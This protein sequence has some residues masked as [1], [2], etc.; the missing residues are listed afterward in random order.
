[1]IR[2]FCDMLGQHDARLLVIAALLCTFAMSTSTTL[3]TRAEAAS[4][5]VRLRWRIASAVAFGSGVWAT[6]FIAMLAYST[7]LPIGYDVGW[8]LA[9]IVAAIGIAFPA[10]AFLLRDKTEILGG[11][12]LGLAIAA[13]HYLGMMAVDGPV[14]LEWNWAGVALSIAVGAGFSV[15]AILA[16]MRMR[17]VVGSASIVALLLAAVLET[18]LIGMYA[19]SFVYDPL[20]PAGPETVAPFWLACAVAGVCFVI[21]ALGL[22]GAM[23]DRHL[24][25]LRSAEATRLHD[26]IAELER[27]RVDLE[28][29]SDGLAYALRTASAASAAKSA[30][31]A[32]MSHELRTPLNAVIGFSELML[33]EAL[34]P[35]GQPRYKEYISDIHNSGAHLL[36]LINDILD[37]SRMEAGKAEIGAEFVSI[38]NIADL[39]RTMV[40]VQARR[41]LVALTVEIEAGLP[42]V[43][44]DERRLKQVLL[45]LLANAV[46]FT[47]LGG[48]VRLSAH[49]NKDGILIEV[50]D[51][52]IGMEEA[53][54]PK[55]LE[56]FGQV[57]N[58][59]SRRY[60]GT[61][62]GLP[63]AKQ[64]V[65]LHGGSLTIASRI[66][67]GTMVSVQLPN[68]RVIERAQA[69]A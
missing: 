29:T 26:Y 20:A 31:L 58:R 35:I 53:D 13:M 52:G 66:N 10:N 69:A 3:Y 18:H 36:S 43:R 68:A 33:S 46:K 16:G 1:M 42:D 12:L 39:V 61:G 30:F 50:A 11:A 65:E 6:H 34:G 25:D 19:V 51:T 14:R 54:I 63:L 64:L 32:A 45:N 23:F 21:L 37:L 22:V 44:G 9:S 60:E 47:P 57:D 67:Q 8:T 62:L 56:P 7:G 38:A 59:L 49:R 24:S 15:A 55:A 2:G 48:E 5:A 27:T 17:G 40:E 28:N 4:G 41:G